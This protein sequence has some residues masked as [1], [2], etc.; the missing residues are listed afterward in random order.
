MTPDRGVPAPGMHRRFLARLA[1]GALWRR[2]SRL[3]IALAAVAVGSSVAAGLGLVARDVDRQV[4][5]ELKAFGPNVLVVP[6]GHR[7]A[8][9]LQETRLGEARATPR[10]D[11]SAW[12]EVALA[13]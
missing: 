1:W 4:A 3:V 12:R 9:G 6:A 10:L 2:R 8:S 5:R 7:V 13:R 11:D